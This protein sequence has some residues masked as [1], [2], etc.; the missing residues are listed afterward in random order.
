MLNDRRDF[1]SA[2]IAFGK[3]YEYLINPKTLFTAG[4]LSAGRRC[5]QSEY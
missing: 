2:V 4:L 3:N 5:R 1:A